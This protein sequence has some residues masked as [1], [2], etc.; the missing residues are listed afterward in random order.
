MSDGF[1]GYDTSFMLD[2]VVCALVLVVP[3]LAFS[4]Y[5][6]KVRRAYALHRN[7]QIALGVLLLVAITAF[8]VDLQL[9]HGGWQN[10]AN[11]DQ[12]SP[13]LH[14]ERLAQAQQILRI[15]LAFAISTPVLWGLTTVL[16]LRRYPNPPVPGSHSQL[17]KALGW[18]SVA[19]L[20]LTS[21]TGLAF[22]YVAFMAK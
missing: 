20:V 6:V 14:G 18:L 9:V 22:Y 5:L 2:A 17:H 13:R 4:L 12:A 21:A 16:A 1:L 8:E 19:D 15:H 10:I 7:L 3:L 11:K